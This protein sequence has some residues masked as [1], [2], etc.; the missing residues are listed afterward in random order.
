MYR[1]YLHASAV[2]IGAVLCIQ[3]ISLA[4]NEVR[5]LPARAVMREVR[6]SYTPAEVPQLHAAIALLNAAGRSTDEMRRNRLSLLLLSHHTA[7]AKP[8]AP[9]TAATAAAAENAARLV[10]EG[11]P[12]SGQGWCALTD[13]ST[14]RR[15]YSQE[16]ERFLDLCHTTAPRE[17]WLLEGR[18]RMAMLL[19]PR[20]PERLQAE[21]LEDVLTAIRQPDPAW[22]IN[23][24]AYIAGG[25]APQRADTI[26][27][28]IL[29]YRPELSAAFERQLQGYRQ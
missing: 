20:L 17:A 1:P 27:R 8:G 3:G 22:G 4:W 13:L 21:A 29:Q 25:I 14:M 18:M 11:A 24:L 19:W 12:A 2:V 16:T 7:A 23:K 9:E 10:A 28:I 6:I 15:G 26:R 5:L